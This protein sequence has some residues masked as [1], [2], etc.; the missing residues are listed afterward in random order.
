[1]VKQRDDTNKQTNTKHEPVEDSIFRHPSIIAAY[2]QLLINV[3]IALSICYMLVHVFYMLKNDVQTKIDYIIRSEINK[4]KL[5]EK[6]YLMNQC[7][8]ELRVPALEEVCSEWFQCINDGKVVT[9]NNFYTLR[10]AKL[11]IQT[12]A[13]IINTFVE[14]IKI[15]ALVVIITTIL[16]SIITINVAFSR[17]ITTYRQD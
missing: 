7:A 13:D 15:K 14:E 17:L 5:C 2:V 3:L 12:I 6:H 1:M 9:D 11:W 8:P 16:L 10:S 4:V